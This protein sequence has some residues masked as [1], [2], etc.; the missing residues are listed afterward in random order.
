MGCVT[1]PLLAKPSRGY[2]WTCAPCSR[3]HEEE[4][5]G[6]EVRHPTPIAPKPKSNAPAPRG[7]GRPRKDRVLAE[8]EENVEI[9]HFKM[10]PFRYFGQYT[11]ADDTL[12]PDDLIFPRTATRVG[13]K[14]QVGSFPVAGAENNLPPD[15]EERGGDSTIEVH[16]LVNEMSPDELAAM[17]LYKDTL[18]RDEKLSHSVDWLTEVIH[19]FTDAWL[20]GRDMATVNMQSPT[21][22]EKWKKVET[23]YTDREWTAS[24]K[25]AFEDGILTY[26]A[27]LRPVRDQV[28]SRTMPEVVRYYGHWKNMKLG[29]ENRRI[30]AA[31]QSGLSIP[32]RPPSRAE[33]SDDDEGSVIKDVSKAHPSCGA[34]R[35]RESDMW[36]K[37]PKGLPTNVLCDNCGLSWRKYADLNVRPFREETIS[38]TKPGDKR[39]GA[40]LNGNNSKRAR[41]NTTSLP[42]QIVQTPPQPRCLACNRT[43]PAQRIL[44]CRQCQFRV[45]A[46]ACG[47]MYDVIETQAWVCDL[48]RN[49]KT[50]DA[51]ITH[52]CLLCPR[53]RRDPKKK[54]LYPPPDTYLRACKPTEGQ[55]WVHTVCSVFIPEVQYS[56]A[57]QLRLVEGISTLPPYRWMNKCTLCDQSGGAVVRC[58]DCPAEYH[59]SCAW[60]AGHKFS[61]EL[62]P[63]K[64]SRREV[65][66]VVDFKDSSG[67]MVPVVTC[68]GHPAHRRESF[69]ICDLNEFGETA[70]QVYCK[71][72]KQAPVTNTHHLLRKARRLDHILN[73]EGSMD[74]ESTQSLPDPHCSQCKTEF[75]PC[76]YPVS[77]NNNNNHPPNANGN[78]VDGNGNGEGPQEWLCHKCYSHN[79]VAMDGIEPAPLSNGFNKLVIR[80]PR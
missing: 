47:E 70:L 27:E 56:D 53:I 5:E 67:C 32:E 11:V 21:R 44:R 59:V 16:S 62:Q 69:D 63:V 15:I 33:A 38:K 7:R 28:G 78:G 80:I 6:H 13:P 66:T 18:T 54:F 14:Y 17:D 79:D 76:F 25:S 12:D 19:R 57:A 20:S 35:T 10:W 51:S 36:W 50:Q 68:K 71:N 23:R 64:A 42:A 41:T 58:S 24:E 55:A 40:P 77:D 3:Q 26:G 22:L 4:V 45:H 30:K 46:G 2:G 48:C 31:R 73:A 29:E 65:T 1:P 72:Y 8:K 61:F 60:K 37:A 9:R 34:C 39:E 52:D 74:S 75:S 43:N 49:E